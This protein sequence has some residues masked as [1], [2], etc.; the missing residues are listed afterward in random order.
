MMK[1]P[2]VKEKIQRAVPPVGVP[3]CEAKSK[4]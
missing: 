1:K 2:C 4:V 3:K